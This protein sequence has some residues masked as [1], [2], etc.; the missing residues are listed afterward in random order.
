MHYSLDSPF[1]HPI[2]PFRLTSTLPLLAATRQQ[3]PC[4]TSPRKHKAPKLHFVSL[5]AITYLAATLLHVPRQ[6]ALLSIREFT[7]GPL[8]AQ[9]MNRVDALGSCG[10]CRLCR[11]RSGI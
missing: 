1:E 5:K 6:L 7:S 8:P 2:A 10:D 3:L 4:D 9:S 11:T